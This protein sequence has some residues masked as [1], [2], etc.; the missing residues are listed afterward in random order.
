[1]ATISALAVFF[2]AALVVVV[3]REPQWAMSELRSLL[4]VTRTKE[5][6]SAE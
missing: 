5:G 6:S 4:G 1:M 2:V 3:L